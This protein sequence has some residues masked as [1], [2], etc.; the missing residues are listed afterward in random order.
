MNQFK[1]TTPFVFLI[2]FGIT[3]VNY[4]YQNTYSNNVA[5]STGIG[6]SE[7]IKEAVN[8]SQNEQEE[9]K[10]KVHKL[11]SIIK[12]K[13]GDNEKELE[14]D[15]PIKEMIVQFNLGDSKKL[16]TD[17][18][19]QVFSSNADMAMPRLPADHLRGT[20]VL[21]Q[22]RYEARRHHPRARHDRVRSFPIGSSGI[23][24]R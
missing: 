7:L 21:A 19:F 10:K 9:I 15:R 1:K 8:T 13:Q 22:D 6:W 14:M 17:E 4:I 5:F 2:F 24:P 20:N 23:E 12:S 11:E 3:T 16:I 18:Q